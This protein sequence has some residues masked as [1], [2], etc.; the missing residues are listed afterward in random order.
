MK[1]ITDTS[2]LFTPEQGKEMDLLVLPLNVAIN[3]NTYREFVDMTSEEFLKQVRAGAIPSSS[4]PS[5]GGYIDAFTSTTEETL[6]I[7]MADGLSGTYQSVEGAKNSIDNNDHVVVF[8]SRTLCGPHRYMAQRAVELRDAGASFEEVVNKVNEIAD[9]SISFLIPSDYDFLKRG[10]RMT[11]LAATMGG[12]LKI[13]PVLTQTAD[14]RKLEKVCTKRTFKKAAEEVGVVM[15][16]FGVTGE[17]WMISV[18]H[19]DIQERVDEA[20]AVLSAK[21]PGAQT[22]VLELSPAFITQGGPSC[23]AIQAHKL[24]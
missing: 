24:V 19:S 20:I 14:G 2:T 21:F 8:N 1:L 4:Q 13:V 6:V 5:V 17:G 11:P 16:K 9:N 7:A 18:S 23:I 3:G 10:G 12:L 15:E 22:Q